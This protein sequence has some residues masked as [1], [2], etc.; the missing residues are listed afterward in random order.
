M[1]VTFY[2]TSTACCPV[3]TKCL[4]FIVLGI[5]RVFMSFC[6]A[7]SEPA[8]SQCSSED[9]RNGKASCYLPHCAFCI[10]TDS[11]RAVQR[12]SAV[13]PSC[14]RQTSPWPPIIG[15]IYKELVWRAEALDG[16]HEAVFVGNRGVRRTSPLA[17]RRCRGQNTVTP[18][19]P[20]LATPRL[21][22]A[23]VSLG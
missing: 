12:T 14:Y 3:Y 16:L 4:H 8:Q 10:E 23:D 2:V 17:L 20:F 11:G 6:L 5:P 1:T 15:R 13:T 18:V 7:A 19:H 9:G 22:T 21:Q